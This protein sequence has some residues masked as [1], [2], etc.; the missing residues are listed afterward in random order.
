MNQ[1]E[2]QERIAYLQNLIVGIGENKSEEIQEEG[3]A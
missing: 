2:I 3:Q 1:Q